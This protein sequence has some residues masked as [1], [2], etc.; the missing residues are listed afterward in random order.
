MSEYSDKK[1]VPCEGGFPA[2]TLAQAQDLMEHA[3][4]WSLNEAGTEIHRDYAFPDFA[5]A[6]SFVNEVGALAEEEGHHPD[7]TLSWGK[8][9]ITLTTHSIGGLSENDIILAAKIGLLQ[10]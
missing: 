10:P 2:L 4:G 1:C 3:P 7:I 9:G 5:T 6:L 8:V